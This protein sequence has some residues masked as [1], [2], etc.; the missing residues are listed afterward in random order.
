MTTTGHLL[1]LLNLKQRRQRV[2][3]VLDHLA[4]SRPG[5][6]FMD[7]K[8]EDMMST[9]HVDEKLFYIKQDRQRYYL[10]P[11]EPV[12]IRKCLSKRYLPKIMFCCAVARP[13]YDYRSKQ[14]F[15]SKL[16][17]WPFAKDVKAKR[18]SKNRP[19]GTI[20]TTPVSVTAPVY[21]AMI[22]DNLLPA[23]KAK[24]PG[25]TTRQIKIQEDNTSAHSAANEL[26]I[27]QEALLKH[28]LHVEVVKQPPRSP[29]FNALDW[30]LQLYPEEGLQCLSQK[31]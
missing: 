25:S 19:A 31:H 7:R 11:D 14:W 15:N 22:V 23:I 2:Q 29:T 13:G 5:L 18:N 21:R 27:A 10:L 16:S 9:I 8:F 6:S 4:D 1:P 24:W 12:P 17:I 28:S 20:V 26:T 30:N 3:F